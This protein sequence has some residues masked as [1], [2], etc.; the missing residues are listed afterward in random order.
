VLPPGDDSYAYWQQMVDG[1]GHDTQ[2][3]LLLPA[4]TNDTYIQQNRIVT[5]Q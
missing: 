1:H 4:S 2:T 5:T 3:G